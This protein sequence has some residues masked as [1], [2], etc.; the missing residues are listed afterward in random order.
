MPMSEATP[1][2]LKANR[3][4]RK[5]P[6]ALAED[7]QPAREAAERDEP[8]D[9]CLRRRAELAVAA[10][11]ANARAA[12]TRAAAFPV[13]KAFATFDGTA[14]PSLREQTG[15]G[16]ARGEGAEQRLNCCVIGGSG[17]GQTH[18]ATGLGLALCRLGK[19]VTGV[20]AAGRV[21]QRQEARPQ[22]RLDRTLPALGRLD[23][24]SADEPGCLSFSRA[25]AALL[26]PA[27]ADRY[28]R[29]RLLLT[30]NPPFGAR[31]QVF[32]GERRTA[33]LP[34]RLRHRRHTFEM[35]GERDRCRASMKAK[36]DKDPKKGK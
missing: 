27:F 30:S 21:A 14:G 3:K 33:A 19:R 6:T 1:L 5:P 23:L 16:P 8:Y 15:L 20:P 10:R 35:S 25:G 29:R 22:H 32:Q 31:G 26:F 18:G 13:L 7:E 2:A 36:K 17:T 24:L 4:Q 28:E 12:R 11:A 9:G 34:G